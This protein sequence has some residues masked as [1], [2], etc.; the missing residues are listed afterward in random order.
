M[1]RRAAGHRDRA[2]VRREVRGQIRNWLLV[3]LIFGG[4][5]TA[6]V[7]IALHGH[8]VPYHPH[9]PNYHPEP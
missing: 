1:G 9:G 4:V 5:I 6:V 3:I 2:E 8:T 7:L